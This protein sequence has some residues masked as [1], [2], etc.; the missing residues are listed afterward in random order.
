MKIKSIEICD[1]KG[2]RGPNHVFNL[3]SKNLLL[4]GENGS[5]KSSLYTALR[6]LLDSSRRVVPFDKNIY[7]DESAGLTG[8]VTLTLDNEDVRKWAEDTT[9][10]D[11]NVLVLSDASKT[12]RFLDYKSLL[13]TYFLSP[14]D[15][16]VNVFDL[17][18]EDILADNVNDLTSTTFQEEW[19]NIHASLPRDNRFTKQRQLLESEIENFNKGLQ[20]KLLEIKPVAQEILGSFDSNLEIDFL[21]NGVSYNKLTKKID[22]QQ[23]LLKVKF[24]NYELAFHHQFLN[25]A[26]LSAIA[27]SVY[28]ASLKQ[29]PAS[30]LRI[31]AFDDVLVGLDYAH[32]LPILE[33]I[34]TH[35]A[36]HQILLLTYDRV[37]Y[38]VVRRQTESGKKWEYLELYTSKQGGLEMPSLREAKPLTMMARG[39]F[40]DHDYKA[41][42][43]YARSAFEV[44]TQKFCDKKGVAVQ[45]RSH[46]KVPE[47]EVFWN[48]VKTWNK[49][50]QPAKI[51]EK[52]IQDVE[53]SKALVLNPLSHAQLT[54]VSSAEV[55]KAIGAVEELEICFEGILKKPTQPAKS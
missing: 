9:Q 15:G 41:A 8:Y 50:Q 48:A 32:R 17:L 24:Y 29:M 2:F 44:A 7:V 40:D 6:N 49:R 14:T 43:V 27:L 13:R 28:F 11:T 25:E 22:G 18:L 46:P 37:W 34:H 53:S 54:T 55:A 1:F 52:I 30:D 38:E 4:Y 45:Y 26:R 10:T 20:A 5:G 36:D 21:F 19:R 33:V 31:L 35:F 51:T 12:K 23:I 3:N 16:V 39:H 47:S 42:A